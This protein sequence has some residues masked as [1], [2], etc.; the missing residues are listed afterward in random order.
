MRVLAWLRGPNLS[1]SPP[2]PSLAGGPRVAAAL[3]FALAVLAFGLAP[4][5]ALAQSNTI[6]YALQ[7]GKTFTEGSTTHTLRVTLSPTPPER[8][9]WQL[10]PQVAPDCQLT[11]N[12]VSES[13]LTGLP[14]PFFGVWPADTASQDYEIGLTRTTCGI[15]PMRS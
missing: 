15:P 4:R 2:E 6:T 14:E 1:A 8:A 11:N 9:F 5:D 13:P 12:S 7:N 10:D 3:L